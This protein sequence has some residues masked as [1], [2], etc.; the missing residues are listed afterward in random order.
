LGAI[1]MVDNAAGVFMLPTPA[2]GILRGVRGVDRAESVE[3]VTGVSISIPFG[4]PVRPL[5]EGD[6]YLGF[7][8]ARGETPAGVEASLRR[9]QS[10]L[11]VVVISA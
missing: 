11:D 5:P 10:L 7:I 8:F 2:P 6:R 4:A 1:H 9:A 3:G